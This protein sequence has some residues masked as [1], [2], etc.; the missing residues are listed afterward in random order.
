[1][2]RIERLVDEHRPRN[3]NGTSKCHPRVTTGSP[4]AMAGPV[5]GSSVW[6]FLS[7]QGRIIT[8]PISVVP[9]I[10]PTSIIL[11]VLCVELTFDIG[12]EEE[13]IV[14]FYR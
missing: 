10:I 7:Y 4:R 14:A 6:R 9:T 13:Q 12:G 1:M 2:L 5:P 8:M 11:G 3:A